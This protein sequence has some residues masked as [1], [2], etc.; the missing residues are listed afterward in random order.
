M[1]APAENALAVPSTPS[2]DARVESA[3]WIR[4]SQTLDAQGCAR[5]EGLL[6]ASECE[7]VAGLYA[8]D[9]VFRSRIV[10]S[11]HGFGRGEYKYFGYP[12]PGIVAALRGA[13]YPRL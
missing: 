7:R 3:D 9:E 12:L 1:N 2:I 6:S 5:I 11:R 8:S 13:L 10:M 4:V